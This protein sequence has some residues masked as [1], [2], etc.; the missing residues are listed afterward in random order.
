MVL[1][2]YS[3]RRPTVDLRVVTSDPVHFVQVITRTVG[4]RIHIINGEMGID[5]DFFIER[6]THTI[7]RTNSPGQPPVH[8]AI[9]G[10]EKAAT[11]STNPF[12]FDVRGAGFDQGIFDPI[13]ADDATS[14]F[15]FDHPTQGVF[16]VGLYGT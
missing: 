11:Q 14:V 6:V 9:F 2:R 7:Q 12:R 5:D 16:D 3:Q 4:D 13:A 1:L 8:G 10:C 15:I